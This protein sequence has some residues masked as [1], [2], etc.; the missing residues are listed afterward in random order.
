MSYTKN[1]ISSLIPSFYNIETKELEST[2]QQKYNIFRSTLFPDPPI[3]PPIDLVLY[4]G[5]NN[6]K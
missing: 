4:I 3:I 6:W 2:F 5:S 1:T